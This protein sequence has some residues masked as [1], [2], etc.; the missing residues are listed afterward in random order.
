MKNGKASQGGCIYILG[1]STLKIHNTSFTDCNAIKQGGAIYASA[2]TNL[3]L[4][5]GNTFTDNI[6]QLQQGDSI[7][8]TNTVNYV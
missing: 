4:S 2:F 5:Y 7:Y 8:A 1:D 3:L 6:S